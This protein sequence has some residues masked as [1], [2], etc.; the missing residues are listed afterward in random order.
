MSVSALT[1]APALSLGTRFVNL[2]QNRAVAITTLFIVSVPLG[3]AG[4]IGM[5]A[6]LDN[7]RV[8][9]NFKLGSVIF[10]SASLPMIVN[11]I[12]AK[13]LGIPLS[14]P[15]NVILGVAGTATCLLAAKVICE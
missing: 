9:E 13:C 14:W 15:I 1:S 6:A 12:L 10:A 7:K 3:F 11:A 2:F 5:G 4:L 8:K